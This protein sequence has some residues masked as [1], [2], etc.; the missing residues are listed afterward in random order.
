MIFVS[1][2][3]VL[4]NKICSYIHVFHCSFGKEKIVNDFMSTWN[5]SLLLP[6]AERLSPAHWT[7][8]SGCAVLRNCFFWCITTKCQKVTASLNKKSNKNCKLNY[9]VFNFVKYLGW[10]WPFWSGFCV[11]LSF[12]INYFQTED[13]LNKIVKCIIKKMLKQI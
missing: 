10:F 12:N 5:R 11:W 3:K 7:Q 8:W 9:L 6:A 13:I 2:Q 4:A 1:K